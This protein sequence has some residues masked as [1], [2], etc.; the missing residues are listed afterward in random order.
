LEDV[1]MARL[2]GALDRRLRDARVEARRGAVAGL[3]PRIQKIRQRRAQPG[4]R[5]VTPGCGAT[6]RDH[7]D[8]DLS[9]RREFWPGIAQRD[10]PPGACRVVGARPEVAAARAWWATVGGLRGEAA[11]E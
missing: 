4:D 9:I 3:R 10:A 8:A 2:H 11:R 5:R 1:G 7:P 6:A